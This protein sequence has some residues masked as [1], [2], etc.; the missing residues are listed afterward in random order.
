[1]LSDA[2][3]YIGGGQ[4]RVYTPANGQVTVSGGTGAVSVGVSGGSRGDQFTLEFA[5]PAGQAL[6]PGVYDDAQRASFRSAGRPGI[7]IYG[8]GRGCNTD[9]GRFEVRDIAVDGSGAV[10]GLWI[11]YE[12]H[13]E[14]GP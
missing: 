9:S 7:D 3:D 13:C 8:D 14:G 6:A 4:P 1:M 11:V 5:A 12:Q 2:G 10:Q